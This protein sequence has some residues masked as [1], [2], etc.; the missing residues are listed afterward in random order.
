MFDILAAVWQ[1]TSGE[2]APLACRLKMTLLFHEC[3]AHMHIFRAFAEQNS[4]H[5]RSLQVK[6]S[7]FDAWLCWCALA[8]QP[9]PLCC[10]LLQPWMHNI[11]RFCCMRQNMC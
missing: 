4:L 11:S 2:G 1:F 8:L 7:T 10:G 9:A 5:R 3:E 6:M